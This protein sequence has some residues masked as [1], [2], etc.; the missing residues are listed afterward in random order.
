MNIIPD[1]VMVAWQMAPFLVLMVGLNLIL[2]KPMVA[3]L[4]ERAHATEGA[5]HE[6]HDLVAKA[7]ARLAEWEQAMAKARNEVTELRSARRAAANV[8]YQ[9]ILAAARAEADKRISA[10]TAGLKMEADRARVELEGNARALAQD[11]ATQVLGR[12]VQVEA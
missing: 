11:V 2:F 7:E 12:P 9:Q 6:A 8:E 4:H 10:A 5:R 3:Y 1:L